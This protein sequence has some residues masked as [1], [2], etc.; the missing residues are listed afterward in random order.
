MIISKN[1]SIDKSQTK[2]FEEEKQ[3]QYKENDCHK[4]SEN[5]DD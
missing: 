5:K 2:I 4:D 3:Q 1:L